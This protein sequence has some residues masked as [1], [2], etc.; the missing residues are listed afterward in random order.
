M[1]FKKTELKNGIRVVTENHPGSRAVSIGVWVL[2]GTRDE[3]SENAGISHFLEHMVFKGTKTR[4]AYQLAKSL[5]Q[6]GGELNAYTTREYTVYHCL[7]LKDHWKKGLEVLSDLVCNMQMRKEDYELE[8]SVILQEIAMGEDDLEDMIYDVYFDK[9]LPKSALGK[10]I[11]GNI[12][13]IA[14]MKMKQ[15]QAYYQRNYSANNI[16]VAAAGNLDHHDL[17][18]AVEEFLG[19]KKKRHFKV[20]RTKP[21]HKPVRFVAEKSSEQV[22]LC[23]GLPVTSFRDR[24]RFDAYIVNALLGGGMTSKLFQSVREK[25]GLVYSIYSSLN[26]FDD[27]GCINIYAACEKKNMKQVVK[28]VGQEILRLRKNKISRHD[29]D[30]FK[31]QV[32]GAVLLGSEDVDNRMS[33][34][35]VNEMVFGKYKPVET[36]IEEIDQVSEK[37]VN[38]FVQRYIVPDSLAMIMMG[39]GA[40]DL[41]PWFLE[42]EVGK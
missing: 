31:T 25:R 14:H 22:H 9:T 30:L 7:L 42:A 17:V 16:I 13:S 10:P 21:V 37:S 40:K 20:D 26:T 11:L 1:Q 32:K 35:A 18:Q 29:L 34:I 3:E 36:V 28:C 38:E 8:R 19:H 24:N 15:L 2:T 27:Y 12:K 41:E 39:G 33:S 23:M 6:L 4:S 5:E